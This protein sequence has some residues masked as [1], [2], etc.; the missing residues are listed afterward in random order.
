MALFAVELHSRKPIGPMPGIGSLPITMT[1][2]PRFHFF[3][4]ARGLHVETSSLGVV[5]EVRC[6]LA[7]ADRKIE[8]HCRSP[9]WFGFGL[10]RVD[11][12]VSRLERAGRIAAHP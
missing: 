4:A 12:S 5:L 7:V 8:G 11:C 9:I 3:A 1:S 10:C 6:D 2:K